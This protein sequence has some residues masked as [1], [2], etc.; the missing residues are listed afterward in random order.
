[1]GRVRL[2]SALAAAASLGALILIACGG[3][4]DD[5]DGIGP[6]GADGGSGETSTLPDGAVLLP[7]GGIFNFPT[8]IKHVIVIVK[9]NHTFDNFFGE[10]DGGP[11]DYPFGIATLHD[12]T[13]IQRPHCPTGGINRDEQQHRP[14]H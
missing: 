12:G 11:G 1:M 9:E 8:P 6:N 13:T 5:D 3:G 4:G 7:D 10:Y 2:L 14:R